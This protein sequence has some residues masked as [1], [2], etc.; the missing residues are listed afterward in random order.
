MVPR[1]FERSRAVKPNF[2][3]FLLFFAS[4]ALAR[5][6]FGAGPPVP[7]AKASDLIAWNGCRFG[8][9]RN[10]CLHN[11]NFLAATRRI[12][13]AL[14]EHYKDHPGVLGWQ[15][16][17]E[18]GGPDCFDSYCQAAFQKWCRSKYQSLEGLNRAWGA[19]FWGHT[20]TA[21]SQVPLPWNTLYEAHSPSLALDYNRFFSD[22]TAD[23]LKFQA[24]ILR[25]IAPSKAITHNEMGLF[26]AIDYSVLN[27]SLDFVAWDNYPM[28]EPD[29]ATY[30]G[31]ALGH[32][33]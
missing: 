23:Y 1:A 22:S 31:P 21:W 32:D 2:R 19:I 26:D 16:D 6:T 24:G 27:A 25:R 33:L 4:A 3:L 30:Y 20:Y 12:V 18:L 28:F 7:A 17:N 11:P 8:S 10:Y 9:R 5:A 15:I 13:T 14:A 29:Y